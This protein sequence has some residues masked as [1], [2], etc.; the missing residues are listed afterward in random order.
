MKAGCN[1]YLLKGIQAVSYFQK[2]PLIRRG[3]SPSWRGKLEEPSSLLRSLHPWMEIVAAAPCSSL[4]LCLQLFPQGQQAALNESEMRLTVAFTAGVSFQPGS[5]SAPPSWWR[6]ARAL[7]LSF[8]I[9]RWGLLGCH[10]FTDLHSWR[11]AACFLGDIPYGSTTETTLRVTLLTL[12]MKRTLAN[13][14]KGYHNLWVIAFES[15][16]L[17]EKKPPGEEHCDKIHGP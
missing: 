13:L 4:G 16:L 7:W 14:S 17:R 8:L 10:T 12:A 15:A 2:S 3:F 6:A 5:S 11:E 1:I 9:Y